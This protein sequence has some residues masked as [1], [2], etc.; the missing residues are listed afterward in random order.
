MFPGFEHP[1]ERFDSRFSKPFHPEVGFL[2]IL[3]CSEYKFLPSDLA[4]KELRVAFET[5]NLLE[6]LRQD[7]SSIEVSVREFKYDSKG[8]SVCLECHPKSILGEP[9]N[10]DRHFQP[11][12]S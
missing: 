9:L 5:T 4:E 8:G 3:Q 1:M 7:Q 2:N 11:K 12:D 10:L 6:K